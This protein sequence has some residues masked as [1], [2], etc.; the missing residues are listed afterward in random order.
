MPVDRARAYRLGGWI[1]TETAKGAYGFRVHWKGENRRSADQVYLTGTHREWSETARA[2]APPAWA[3]GADIACFAYGNTGRIF[4]DDVSFT[5]A[6]GGSPK[7]PAEYDVAFERLRLELALAGTFDVTRD[8]TPLA[9]DGGLFIDEA[10]KVSTGQRIADAHKP[11]GGE[12]GRTFGGKVPYFT[13][14]GVLNYS[15]RVSPGDN[16]LAV[17]YE[18]TSDRP[19]QPK[20]AGV[21]LT[22]PGGAPARMLDDEGTVL[23]EAKGDVV[24]RELLLEWP[25]GGT[26]AVYASGEQPG[27]FRVTASGEGR[28]V[29]VL[30]PAGIGFGEEPSKLAFEINAASRVERRPVERLWKTHKGAREAGD[31]PG[32]CGVL[33]AITALAERFPDDAASAKEQLAALEEQAGKES[34][35]LETRIAGLEGAGGDEREALRSEI[36]KALGELKVKYPLASLAER[37]RLVESEL[38][39]ALEMLGKADRDAKA[40]EFLERIA[41][42]IRQEQ[43]DEALTGW[44][45]LGKEFPDAPALREGQQLD[46]QGRIESGRQAKRERLAA[47]EK[48]KK[49]I[50]V[51]R[52]NN[53]SDQALKRLET[54]PDYKRHAESREFKQL[55]EEVRRE[56]EESPPSEK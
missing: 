42:F 17:E 3:T 5:P 33:E 36:E 43:Y 2:F 56:A 55:H 21:R 35:A 10:K 26:L 11:K 45:R 50:A 51:Y 25:D 18:V 27:R 30:W 20:R 22:V 24:A 39:D 38:A 54:D 46:I 48:V 19:L 6:P 29:E 14:G 7:A 52:K 28:L 47:L 41:E 8:G 44:E 32:E 4:F 53:M 16:G 15:Q 12:A 34:E 13:T 49:K 40:Q 31:V 1:R 9:T 23:P 37:A